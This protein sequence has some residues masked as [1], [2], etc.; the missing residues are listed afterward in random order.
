MGN[1]KIDFR[2]EAVAS[3]GKA[4]SVQV[5]GPQIF[6]SLVFVIAPNI[7]VSARKIRTDE[8]ITYLFS[9]SKN[10]NNLHRILNPTHRCAGTNARQLLIARNMSEAEISTSVLAKN[11]LK[12]TKQRLR[13]LIAYVFS[14]YWGL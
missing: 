9:A 1:V 3:K 2:H 6:S 14:T 8:L 5:R 4:C 7:A 11:E 12:L 13:R 10:M